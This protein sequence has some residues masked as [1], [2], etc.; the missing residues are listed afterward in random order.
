MVDESCLLFYLTLYHILLD[1][2]WVF[3]SIVI[4]PEVQQNAGKWEIFFFHLLMVASA[5]L[6]FSRPDEEGHC[7]K[8]LIEPSHLFANKV[9]AVNFQEP[10]IL[11]ILLQRPVASPSILVVED[12]LGFLFLVL[13]VFFSFW[14]TFSF[15]GGWINSLVFRHHLARVG[16]VRRHLIIR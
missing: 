3:C 2:A 1:C 14:A 5:L 9:F 4:F 12:S 13:G 8:D 7:L 16:E 11:F 15:W 6:S 10:M